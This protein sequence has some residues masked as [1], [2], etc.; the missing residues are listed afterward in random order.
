MGFVGYWVPVDVLAY[1][2]VELSFSLAAGSR[3]SSTSTGES[4][5]SGGGCGLEVFHCANPH[6]VP[7][8]SLVPVL[9]GTLSNNAGA[10]I[11]V[12]E[13]WEWLERLEK[14][15]TA[16]TTS[17]DLERNPAVK[18]VDFYRRLIV[19][20]PRGS[21]PSSVRLCLQKTGRVSSSLATLGPI[22]PE[23]MAVRVQ[24]WLDD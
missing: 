1:V 9:V 22:Q 12:I 7:W 8:G 15:A 17:T 4:S 13:F 16:T 19:D 6:P 11:S 10:D 3:R 21:A 23:W 2:L 18:L 24:D 14:S 20:D 5:S